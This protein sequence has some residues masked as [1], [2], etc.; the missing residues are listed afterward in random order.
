VI[1]SNSVS[2]VASEPAILTVVP[3]TARPTVLSVVGELDPTKI[4]VTFSEAMDSSVA[5]DSFVVF[6]TGSGPSSSSALLTTAVEFTSDK[7]AVI[8]TTEQRDPSIHYSMQLTQL[9]DASSQRNAI[10]PDPTIVPLQIVVGLIGF[11]TNNEWRWNLGNGDLFGTGWESVDYDDSAWP[12]GPAGLGLDLLTN[13]VPIRTS[14]PYV[15][16]GAPAYFRRHFS[17]PA[18]THGATL[19]L[20]H[21]IDDGAVYYIN[22]QEVGRFRVGNGSLSFASRASAAAPEPTPIEGPFNLP[23]TNLVSGDNVIAVSLL[24]SGSFSSDIMFAAE[25]TATVATT[26]EAF[27]PTIV[28]QPQSQ[29]VREGRGAA[30]TVVAQGTSPLHYQWSKNGI[31]LPGATNSAYFIAEVSPPDSGGYRVV[32]T[33]VY[34]SVPSQVASLSVIP[35]DPPLFLS[36]IGHT[37]L[38]NITLSFSERMH[39]ENTEV[40]GHYLIHNA[41]AP[42]A[43]LSA[44]LTHGTNVLLITSP[45]NPNQDYWITLQ[46]VTDHS[47]AQNRPTPTT[48]AVSSERLVLAPNDFMAWRFNQANTDLGTAWREV[49]YD[50]DQ[51]GWNMG[52]PGFSSAGEV[53]PT[54]FEF[55]TDTLT[56][57]TNGGPNT[58]YFRTRFAF[59][60][61]TNGARIYAVGVVDDGAVFYINGFEAARLRMTNSSVEFGHPA[62][63]P[64]MEGTNGH[65]AEGPIA[66]STD[67]IVPFAENLLAVELHQFGVSSDAA[68]SIQLI[69]ILDS[70]QTGPALRIS[71]DAVSGRVSIFRTREG[72]LQSATE[73]IPAGTGAGGG[74]VWSNVSGNP[75]PHI[76]TPTT[77]GS[78][79]FRLGN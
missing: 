32:I 48:R 11:D 2:F 69:A 16:D 26:Y 13:Q 50:D 21:V 78:R 43:I 77:N 44:T 34:G 64:G 41:K 23:A 31:D 5:D 62:A 57:M 76:F 36:A 8:L 18:N 22:G 53:A 30:F 37:N 70:T 38:T 73:L 65:L 19:K 60:G 49:D 71:R 42:L 7:T 52:F 63:A 56:S 47:L 4:T 79:F 10:N 61:M 28:T 9:F 1:V 67:S 68:L 33:N 51:A 20:R 74:T 24:Q 15:N 66:L 12:A 27:A 14:L 54:G 35:A 29:V 25:L 72:T 46:G 17:L 75:E 6:P 55:R 59:P 39:P 40:P 45:R 58:I 3:D